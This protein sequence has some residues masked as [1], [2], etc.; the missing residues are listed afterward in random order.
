VSLFGGGF[1]VVGAG[2][3]TGAV[4]AGGVV[5]DWARAG[6]TDARQTATKINVRARR[7]RLVNMDRADYCA[8]TLHDSYAKSKCRK[9]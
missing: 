8:G 7:W 9:E 2:L 4:T 1:L 3:A 5:L 6:A